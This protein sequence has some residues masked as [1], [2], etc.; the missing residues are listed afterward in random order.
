M[1]PAVC[2][3]RRFVLLAVLAGT[4]VLGISVPAESAYP[5][6]PAKVERILEQDWCRPASYA[7][8]RRVAP[9]LNLTQWRN[10]FE[11]ERLARRYR[12]GCLLAEAAAHGRLERL[13]STGA[14]WTRRG[15]HGDPCPDCALPLGTSW[16]REASRAAAA[17]EG[18][19]RRPIVISRH[20]ALHDGRIRY[21]CGAAAEDRSMVVALSLTGLL[22]SASLSERVVAVARFPRYGWRVYLVLH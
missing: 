8:A 1:L 10:L 7:R 19:P 15:P 5:G 14:P 18:R 13:P 20:R 12:D 2:A 4:A 21:A 6:M 9:T 22:P 11:S 17:A 3:L 16:R